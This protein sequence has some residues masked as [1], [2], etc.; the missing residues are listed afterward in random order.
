M[1]ESRI[2]KKH[3]EETKNKIRQNSLKLKHTEESKIKMKLAA[4]KRWN[5]IIPES[6]KEQRSL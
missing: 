4:I 3:S 1:R 5:K 6:L 2:G